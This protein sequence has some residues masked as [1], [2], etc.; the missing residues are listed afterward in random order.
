MPCS[1]CCL[2]LATATSARLTFACSAAVLLLPCMCTVQIIESF[3]SHLAAM[4]P[5][6]EG[7]DEAIA[8]YQAWRTWTLGVLQ[9][10]LRGHSASLAPVVAQLQ[11]QVSQLDDT[12]EDVRAVFNLYCNMS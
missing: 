1:V 9:A 8:S 11:K 5:A 6:A 2:V 7:E 4:E 3:I 12:L 10:F